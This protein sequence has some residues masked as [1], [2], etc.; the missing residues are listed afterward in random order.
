MI[1]RGNLTEEVFGEYLA[2]HSI[3]LKK[4]R[5]ILASLN[6]EVSKINRQIV[7]C[8]QGEKKPY[9]IYDSVKDKQEG[10]IEF[11]LEFLNSIDTAVLPPSNSKMK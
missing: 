8:L 11:T 1:S 9:K 10:G 5:V 6:R 2:N 7:D 3:D 4:E